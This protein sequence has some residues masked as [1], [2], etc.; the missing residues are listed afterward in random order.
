MADGISLRVLTSEVTKAFA[1]IE[2]SADRSTMYTV[3]QA[4]RKVG[5]YAR[6]AAPVYTGP[7]R[8][9]YFQGQN[10]GPMAKGDLKKSIRSAKRLSRVAG[11]YGVTIGPRGVANIYAGAQE[12]RRPFMGPAREQVEGEITSIAEA[13]WGRSMKRG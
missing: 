7:A 10:I 5:Q 6:K 3:R 2:K 1:A 11:G 9:R 13:A 8:D 12:V 4:A